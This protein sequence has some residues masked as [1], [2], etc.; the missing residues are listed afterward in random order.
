MAVKRSTIAVVDIRGGRNG[1]DPPL[2]LPEN[3][4][5][6]AFNVDWYDGTLG[7]KR[8]GHSAISILTADVNVG[9]IAPGITSLVR[10]HS[11]EGPAEGIAEL[12]ALGLGTANAW[13]MSRRR[14]GSW[15][16]PSQKDAPSG[17]GTLRMRGASLDGKLFLAYRSAVDR[18]H[19]WDGSTVRRTGMA[20][21]AAATVANNGTVGVYATTIR[22]YKIAYTEV[23]S[24]VVVRRSELSAKVTFT[25]DGA[26]SAATVTK[27]AAASEGET[28]W[29]IYGS[30]DDNVYYYITTTVVGTTTYDDSAVPTAYTSGAA[31]PVVGTNTNWP[32]VDYLFTDGN[33]LLG[34]VGTRIY[35]SS[36]VGSGTGDTE[37]VAATLTESHYFDLDDGNGDIISGFAGPVQGTIFVFKHR[38]IWR[39]TPNF[40]GDLSAPWDVHPVA[41]STGAVSQESIVTAE[42]AQGAPAI[43]FWG[44]RGPYRMGKAGIEW[45]GNG[46]KDRIAVKTSSI[47]ATLWVESLHQVWFHTG[48][49]DE[50]RLRWVWD[51]QYSAWSRQRLVLPT[52]WTALSVQCAA[53]FAETAATPYE[54][55]PF[56]AG[57]RT[58]SGVTG[59][60]LWK[61]NSGT[62]DLT[63]G[64]YQAYIK[65][66]TYP[67]HE[68]TGRGGVDPPILYAEALAATSLQVTTI[69]DHNVATR[70]ATVSIAP[71]GTESHVSKPVHGCELAQCQTVAYQI[72]DAAAIDSAWTLCG[73]VVGV[74]QEETL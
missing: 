50:E 27:P 22:Y 55:Q 12:W 64:L 60:F 43:Y 51:T 44:N 25:P 46:L 21:P 61:G 16:N 49:V 34:A 11:D 48:V 63:G 53:M 37:R 13:D 5:E 41:F 2:S 24:S 68:M 31:E 39:L 57:W 52:D 10:H 67:V 6:E 42:D 7:R 18:L 28:N 74:H 71:S 9:T 3:V 19:V 58:V 59:A 1:D 15:T 36:V 23:V 47:V 66:K 73:L 26:H 65:T 29:E 32:S 62:T 8:P 54:V 38:S 33:R 20:T 56:V 40:G 70:S 45:L 72:G 30:A 35:F 69:R 14:L 4:C 17:S